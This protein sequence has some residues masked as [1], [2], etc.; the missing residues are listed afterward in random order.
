MQRDVQPPRCQRCPVRRVLAA[1]SSRSPG[2]AVCV[3][4]V[5]KD[6][7][8]QRVGLPLAASAG[9]GFRPER[10]GRRIEPRQ[11]QLL[12]HG[13]PVVAS[14]GD[15]VRSLLIHS[16]SA[17]RSLPSMSASSLSS[18]SGLGGWSSRSAIA[19][20]PTS[21]TC[22]VHPSPAD[23]QAAGSVAARPGQN[24]Y[25]VPQLRTRLELGH[26]RLVSKQR[27]VFQRLYRQCAD[28]RLR[29]GA[30]PTHPPRPDR[31]CDGQTGAIEDGVPVCT[32]AAYRGTWRRALGRNNLRM[33]P[34]DGE[35][36]LTS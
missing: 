31:P 4:G 26:R 7:E 8:E 22:R 19:A 21:A 36:R 3:V 18:G 16:L 20:T 1:Q 29:M 30:A 35:Q 11:T 28:R 12:R 14:D 10:R 15:R 25:L 27:A 24:P 2:Q 13:G 5:R 32:A 9:H 17:G 33:G 6:R 23:P 34:S